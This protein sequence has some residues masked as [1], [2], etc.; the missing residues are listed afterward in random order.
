MVA[1]RL[2]RDTRAH[3]ALVAV[4]ISYDS[5]REE[6]SAINE[7]KVGKDRT[8]GQRVKREFRNGYAGAACTNLQ[9]LQASKTP[10]HPAGRSP[11]F[12]HGNSLLSRARQLAAALEVSS[13]RRTGGC[14]GKGSCAHPGRQEY[15]KLA[16]AFS[17]LGRH[18]KFQRQRPQ[19]L[20]LGARGSC[21]VRGILVLLSSTSTRQGEAGARGGR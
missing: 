4:K 10:G 9:C 15:C 8:K 17:P 16:L 13:L 2:I 19:R 20:G 7:N 14:A 3:K 18:S 1:L 11:F 21:E 12:Y 5:H 6:T